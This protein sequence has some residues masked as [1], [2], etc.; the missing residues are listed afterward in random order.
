MDICLLDLEKHIQVSIYL[1]PCYDKTE[2]FFALLPGLEFILAVLPLQ[3]S[4][5]TVIP[6]L[7]HVSCK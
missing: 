4:L 2:P 1:S 3:K 5:K 7:F 6:F